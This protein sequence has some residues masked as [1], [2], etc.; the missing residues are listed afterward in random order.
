MKDNTSDCTIIRFKACEAISD[1]L[2]CFLDSYF[3]VSSIDYLDNGLQQYVAYEALFDEEHFLNAAKN[4]AVELPNYTVEQMKNQNWLKLNEV[5]FE[6]FETADFCIYGMHE[7]ESPKT[8]KIP[9]QIDAATAF[10]STHSTTCLCLKALCYLYKSGF[11]PKRILDVGTGSGILAVAAA[12]RWHVL[13]PSITGVDIDKESLKVACENALRNKASQF[14]QTAYSNGLKAKIVSQNGPYDLIFAN[15]LARPLIKMA[16]DM[17][18]KIKPAGCVILSGFMDTQENWV[19]KAYEKHGFKRVKIYYEEHWCTAVM[20]KKEVLHDIR[21]N[22]EPTQAFLIEKNNMFLSEDVLDFENKIL[23]LTGFTGS[24]G[25]LVLTKDKT[26]LIVDGRYTLQAKT[27]VFQGVEVVESQNFFETLKNILYQH[28]VKTVR[29]NPWCVCQ[30]KADKLAQAG[31]CLKADAT[32]A[33][34]NIYTPDK[35]FMHALR[36]SGVSCKQKADMVAKAI[37][38]GFDALLISSAEE[39]SWLSNLRAHDL[40]CSPIYRAFALLKKNGILKT[41]GCHQMKNLAADLKKCKHIVYD[42]NST[43][44]ALVQSLENAEDIGFDFIAKQKLQK[45]PV[46]LQGFIDAHIRDG[47]ALVRFLY[48]LESNKT[49]SE[50]DIVQKLH[51]LRQKGKY[52][53]SESFETIAAIASNGAIVHYQPT[54]KTNK[55]L[56]KNCL[57]LI[58]SGAQ[59]FDGTT[60]I[61]RTIGFGKTSRQIKKDYTLVLKAHIALASSEF[62]YGMKTCELDKICRNVMLNEKKD[63]KHGTGHSVG[64]FSN[65]H[66]PPF[67]INANNQTLVLE[68]YVTSIEPGIYVENAYGIRIENLYYT[69]KCGN[70]LC[71]EPL[72]LCPIDL[73]LVDSSLLSGEE[74]TWLNAYHQRVFDALKPFLNKKVRLW[75]KEKCREI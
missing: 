8:K 35:V 3:T 30:S 31:F 56:K 32:V 11:Q 40:P 26:F 34:S 75:L 16:R 54:A 24:A 61:T 36:F 28:A 52:Y 15:I 64:H 20:Q 39:V 55:Y 67:A 72:T 44:Y 70:K 27:Q 19:L 58:D 33:A 65:V 42:K 51:E 4:V 5:K 7:K 25:V 12:K 60:D 50:L 45:N 10:G 13:K 2:S 21:Q 63:F 74:K 29:F 9:I 71:F 53:F 49:V 22:L 37:P 14:M 62:E 17:S 41:Y 66:E 18:N 48:W 46:E 38:L 6:R 23:E 59:Y 69:K 68:N 73:S 47:V 1:Q 57:C 43:P